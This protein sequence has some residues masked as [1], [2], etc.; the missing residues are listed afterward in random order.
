MNGFIVTSII[1]ARPDRLRAALRRRVKW[2][3]RNGLT[4]SHMEIIL[5]G[6]A[7]PG[8]HIG[9]KN[10]RLR[11]HLSTPSRGLRGARLLN[12]RK[13]TCTRQNTRRLRHRIIATHRAHRN[14]RRRRLTARTTTIT[15]VDSDAQ[16]G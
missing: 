13:A 3:A 10:T 7:A 1:S 14:G 12:T 5:F 6:S 2:Y 11:A 8:R 4:P 16:S 15:G 9:M